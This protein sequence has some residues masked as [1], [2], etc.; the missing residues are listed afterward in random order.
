MQRDLIEENRKREQKQIEASRTEGQ[1]FD[2][3]NENAKL[4]TLNAKLKITL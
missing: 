2:A 1:L 4:S 3:T